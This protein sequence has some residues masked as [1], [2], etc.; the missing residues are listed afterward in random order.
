M[1]SQDDDSTG[2]V[3]GVIF[4]VIAWVVSLV[5]GVTIYQ[6]SK[7][8]KAQAAMASLAAPAAGAGAGAAGVVVEGGVVKFSLP[9]ARPSSALLRCGICLNLLAW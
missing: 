2:L 3:M 4:G 8:V 5:I 1:V 7:A 6:K 9:L